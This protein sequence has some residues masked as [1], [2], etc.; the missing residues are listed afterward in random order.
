MASWLFGEDP[1]MSTSHFSLELF[2]FSREGSSKPCLVYVSMT[3]GILELNKDKELGN[4]IYPAIKIV[5][6]PYFLYSIS[7]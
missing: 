1:H 4:V 2:R 3:D 6:D 5:L 7:P